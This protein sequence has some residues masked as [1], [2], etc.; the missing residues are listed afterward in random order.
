MV[1]RVNACNLL[2]EHIKDYFLNPGYEVIIGDYD[3]AIEIEEDKCH[4][5]FEL[6][7]YYY[8][9]SSQAERDRVFAYF[10]QKDIVCHLFA[11]MIL[12]LRMAKLG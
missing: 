9:S 3:T 12:G 4:F 5:S 10:D 8:D 6:S 2:D 7:K 1:S 11:D